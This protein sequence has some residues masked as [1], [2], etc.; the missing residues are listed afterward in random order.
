MSLRAVS[1]DTIEPGGPD[2]DSIRGRARHDRKRRQMGAAVALAAV[3]ATAVGLRILLV[4]TPT[5]VEPAPSPL[6]PTSGAV[7]Y[8]ANGL[9]LDDKVFD[10]GVG[11]PTGLSS[12]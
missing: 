4:P 3:I 12:Q 5:T 2:M 8:D 11:Q 7:W 6:T 1:R 9:H 10:V